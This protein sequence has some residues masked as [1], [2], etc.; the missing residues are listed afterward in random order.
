MTEEPIDQEAQRVFDALD[1]V[2]AMTDPLARA[3]VIGLLLKDQAK[4]NKKFH[5]YRRQVVLELREQKVPY[6]KIAEQLGV[7]LGTV[8]DIERGAGRW[9]QRPRKDS[10]QDAPE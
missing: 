10:P 7:S 6:R 4:R 8:Q 5:E 2:E 3:R 1:E 9:T